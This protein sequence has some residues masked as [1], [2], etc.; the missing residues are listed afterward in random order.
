MFRFPVVQRRAATILILAL[1]GCGSDPGEPT[2]PRDLTL[3]LS[4]ASASVAAG[5]S[6]TVTVTV[7]RSEGFTSAVMIAAI[8]APAGVTVTGGAIAAG[9]DSRLLTITAAAGTAAT[10]ADLEVSATTGGG[11]GIN[12]DAVELALT[13]T[14]VVSDQIGDGI[15]GEMAYDEAGT[16]VA[17]SADGTRVVIVSPFNDATGNNAGHAR[18]F[19]RN[20]EAWTQLG[21]DID[22]EAAEDRFGMSAAISED[23]NRI[24]VGS[25][26]NDGGGGAS[27][28]VRLFDYIGGAWTQVGGDIDGSAGRGSG[29]AVALSATGA[30]VVIGG[31]GVGS[32]NG[33]VKVYE[34]VAGSWTQVG[35]TFAE[36]H[37]FGYAVAIS[38]DGNR[39]ALS[40]P[41]AS[42]SALPGSTQAY[43]WNGSAWIQVGSTILGEDIGD[44][45]GTALSLS[46]DGGLLAIGAYSNEGQGLAG[47]GAAGGHLRVY[48]LVAGTWSQV[49]ADLDGAPG[50]N[51]GWSVSLS[52]DGTRLMAGGLGVGDDGIRFYTLAGD[53]WTQSPTP[54]FGP[55]GRLGKVAISADGST[56]AVGE[57]YFAGTAGS[58][59]GV[60][61]LYQLP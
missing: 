11:A 29:W 5:A 60:V 32:E 19:Q 47:G 35:G 55:G 16:D 27:G 30:R 41:S 36:S 15:E 39:I 20:G 46:A 48:R 25:Y 8:G 24:A 56:A 6:T 33:H 3:S 2:P 13:V 34:L 12:A 10:T 57:V 18:V 26:L 23:G 52:D 59:T 44:F 28:H 21:A 58:A 31:P 49:G 40:Y 1:A 51:F 22:G 43:D 4:S 54:D 50:D 17:L 9:E 7:T 14:A 42:G 38:D 45:S 37:E 53:S 61:R